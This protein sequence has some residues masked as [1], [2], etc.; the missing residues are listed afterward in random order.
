VVTLAVLRSIAR[1]EAAEEDTGAA[2][3]AALILMYVV[4]AMLVLGSAPVAVAVG[5]GVAVLLQL[6]QPLHGA[7]RRLSAADMR[8]LMQFA[9]VSA[10]I[11]PVLPDEAFGPYN[12]LN[13]RHIWLMVVLIVGISIAGYLA[14][15]FLGDRIGVLAGGLLGGLISSTA[16]TVSFARRT[17]ASPDAVGVAAA[18]IMIATAVS[19]VRIIIE[20]AAVAPGPFVA[21]AGAPIGA[22]AAL[23]A[24]LGL[25]FWWK[26]RDGAT[27]PEPSNPSELK[28]ALIFAAIYAGVLLLVAAVRE[29]FGEGALYAVALVSGAVDLDAITLSVSGM[30]KSERLEGHQAWRYIM[31][32]ATSNMAF[33]TI[34]C[35]ILGARRL[36]LWLGALFGV[37]AVAS[38]AMILF[39]PAGAPPA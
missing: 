2:T 23:T 27:A 28:A 17:A 22:L 29:R 12:V 18:V 10:V 36:A 34:A 21:Q 19:Y 30:V 8:A 37:C 25:L 6:K 13:P 32:A 1:H 7:V 4:G 16:T 11:L 14:F 15:R 31:A 24:A 9:L 33:K 35:A 3:Q 5:G 39:W 38:V 26:R 20:I